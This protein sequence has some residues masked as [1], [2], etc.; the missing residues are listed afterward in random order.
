MPYLAYP[1][2]PVIFCFTSILLNLENPV[3]LVFIEK[4]LYKKILL[5]R[6]II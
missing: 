5:N 6:E 1:A 2:Y 4:R 3:I